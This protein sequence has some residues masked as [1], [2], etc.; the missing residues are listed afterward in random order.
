MEQV[1]DDDDIDAADGNTDGGRGR[2][3][4]NNGDDYDDAA[5]EEK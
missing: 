1:R 5:D 3:D 4:D 2:G